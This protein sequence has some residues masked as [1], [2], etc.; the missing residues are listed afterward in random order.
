[1]PYSINGIGTQVIK[2]RG[3][4]KFGNF[5]AIECI[6]F[7]YMPIFPIRAVH[8]FCWLGPEYKSI[9][10]K[11][12][13]DLISR[14]FLGRWLCALPFVIG[15][16]LSFVGIAQIFSRHEISSDI[17]N[18][19]LFLIVGAICK[20]WLFA[21]DMRTKA[22]RDILGNHDFG[23]SDP[24][25]WTNEFLKLLRSSE[26]VCGE[27]SDSAAAEHFLKEGQFREAMWHA[28]VTVVFED[29]KRG[30]NLTDRVIGGYRAINS[31]TSTGT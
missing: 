5:D 26:E 31:P 1:M 20:Y 9:P 28:R 10:I 22:I 27:A 15:G 14:V 11:Q 23:S 3:E 29:E 16:A 4:C 12:S 19:L 18:G 17:V 6:V 24:A 8:T 25:T 13:F 7:L 2:G 30:E 21:T